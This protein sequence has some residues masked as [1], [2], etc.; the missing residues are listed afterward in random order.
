MSF[1]VITF[2]PKSERP[3]I[4]V[5]GRERRF[6]EENLG[7]SILAARGEDMK[8]QNQANLKIIID[9]QVPLGRPLTHKGQ[10]QLQVSSNTEVILSLLLFTR[11]PK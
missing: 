8:L 10:T 11:H 2:C 9:G 3:K 7:N 5:K 6:S 1:L 4:T